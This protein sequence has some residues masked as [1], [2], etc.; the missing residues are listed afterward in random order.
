MAISYTLTKL[1]SPG[2]ELQTTHNSIVFE[3][4]VAYCCE[5]CVN[6]ALS[7]DP[8]IPIYELLGTSCGAEFFLEE[9]EIKPLTQD[10]EE[11]W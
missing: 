9:S 10:K 3:T 11:H 4:L 2:F 8:T 1:S 6:E 5:D 7:G